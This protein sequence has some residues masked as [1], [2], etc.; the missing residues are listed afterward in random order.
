MNTKL[1]VLGAV[2]GTAPALLPV[3]CTSWAPPSHKREEE[4]RGGASRQADH[5]IGG[6]G[7]E[8]LP[9]TQVAPGLAPGVPTHPCE[10]I[11]VM[12]VPCDPSAA[13][14]EYTYW[15]CPESVQPLRA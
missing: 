12:Q 7:A 14:C 5:P 10:L 9:P 2:L 4:P 1:Y 6:N 15:E 8:P 3:A 11:T 13:T